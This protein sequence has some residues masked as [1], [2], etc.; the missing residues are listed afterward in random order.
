VLIF[1]IFHNQRI[2]CSDSL[3]KNSKSKNRIGC[4]KNLK[5]MAVFMKE[6][7]H[8]QLTSVACA[9]GPS[10]TTSSTDFSFQNLVF[11]EFI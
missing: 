11:L 4:S 6:P 8:K 5:E 9:V 7:V 10:V 2:T 3:K 1:Q